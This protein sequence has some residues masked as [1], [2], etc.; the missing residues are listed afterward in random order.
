MP[1]GCRF[2]KTAVSFQGAVCINILLLINTLR[3]KSLFDFDSGAPCDG[4]MVTLGPGF[5]FKTPYPPELADIRSRPVCSILHQCLRTV[6][7]WSVRMACLRA[8]HVD[9]LN[10]SQYFTFFPF[11][12]GLKSKSAICFL[13]GY[14]FNRD[15]CIAC[16]LIR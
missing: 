11:F 4:I 8:C 10:F 1:T 12:F 3:S 7:P 2:E 16:G 6:C 5:F 14:K 9:L 13:G 15:D